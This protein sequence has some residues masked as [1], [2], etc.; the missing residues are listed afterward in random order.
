MSG[1]FVRAVVR[2]IFAVSVL[3]L[4]C[5]SVSAQTS[6]MDIRDFSRVSLEG[7]RP[8]LKGSMD[9]AFLNSVWFL[10]GRV[11]AGELFTVVFEIPYTHIE[12][13]YARR[14]YGP[15]ISYDQQSLHG[16]PYFGFELGRRTGGYY[17]LFGIR[18]PIAPEIRDFTSGRSLFGYYDRLEAFLENRLSIT[19]GV[20]FRSEDPA[21]TSELMEIS[22][23]Y[24][25]PTRQH[26]MI[27]LERELHF[28]YRVGIRFR[29]N[30][31][32]FIWALKGRLLVTEPDLDLGERSDHFMGAGVDFRINEFYPGF[33]AYWPL[34]EYLND[35]FELVYGIS[36]TASL[37][38]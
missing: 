31:I 32:G 35:Y 8:S 34:D 15:S 4:I 26:P 29:T 10:E 3:I 22:G 25:I 12:V 28:N 14:E 6:W 9:P 19:S 7:S 20:G 21:L 1:F 13:D 30:S 11:G 24:V 18:P 23:T 5:P 38:N 37:G 16:N 17:G 33:F 27:H 36:L 2:S